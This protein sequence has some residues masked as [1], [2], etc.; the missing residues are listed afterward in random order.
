MKNKKEGTD[1][2]S[3]G[4][5]PQSLL[6]VPTALSITQARNLWNPLF[7][8]HVAGVGLLAM[9]EVFRVYYKARLYR[10]CLCLFSVCWIFACRTLEKENMDLKA[11]N[12]K[13]VTKVTDLENEKAELQSELE[14]MQLL[15]KFKNKDFVKERDELQGEISELQLLVEDLKAQVRKTC[16]RRKSSLAYFRE[17]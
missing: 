13:L 8:L 14:Q 9:L 17:L 7:F 10:D 2:R 3:G 12:Q 1:T 6:R 15:S 11:W 4:F 16:D 5:F